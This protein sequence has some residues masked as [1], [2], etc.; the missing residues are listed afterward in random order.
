MAANFIDFRRGVMHVKAHGALVA[1]YIDRR[2]LPG[3]GSCFAPR[4]EPGEA[5]YLTDDGE[6]TIVANEPAQ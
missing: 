1:R 5:L 3:I 6:F 4:L 2:N